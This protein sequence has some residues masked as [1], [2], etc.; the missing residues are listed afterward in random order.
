MKGP[1]SVIASSV[2]AASTV[3]LSS[4][5]SSFTPGDRDLPVNPSITQKGKSMSAGAPSP[6]KGK[7]APNFDGL[8]FIETLIT[9]HR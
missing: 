6:E 1:C 7:F 2:I 3:V 9:A 4:S 5:P 8:R